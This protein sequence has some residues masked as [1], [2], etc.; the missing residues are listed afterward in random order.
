MHKKVLIV[1]I[2]GANKFYERLGD[3]SV[4]FFLSCSDESSKSDFKIIKKF[5]G[6]AAQIIQHEVDHCDGVLI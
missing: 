1:D 3:K 6:F 4:F 2:I 5:D